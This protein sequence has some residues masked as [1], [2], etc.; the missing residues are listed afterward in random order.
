MK[1]Y[2]TRVP[3]FRL[4]LAAVLCFLACITASAQARHTVAEPEDGAR[5]SLLTPRLELVVGGGEALVVGSVHSFTRPGAL[6]SANIRS[7]FYIRLTDISGNPLDI[8]PYFDAGDRKKNKVWVVLPDN[9]PLVDA[10]NAGQTS[11]VFF[12]SVSPNVAWRGA[13]ASVQYDNP[14]NPAGFDPSY[15][16]GPKAGQLLH[17]ELVTVPAGQGLPGIQGDIPATQEYH[18]VRFY[19]RAPRNVALLGLTGTDRLR[20]QARISVG[21]G[22]PHGGDIDIESA[23]AEVSVVPD[24]VQNVEIF[25]SCGRPAGTVVPMEGWSPISTSDALAAGYSTGTPRNA[26][27]G[28]EFYKGYFFRSS[29]AVPPSTGIA[30]PTPVEPVNKGIGGFLA[31]DESLDR[32]CTSPI[33]LDTVMVSEHDQQIRVVARLLD[34]FNNPVGG[35]LVKFLVESE[36]LPITPPKTRKQ[37]NAQR[38]G[39]GEFGETFVSDDTVKRTTIGDTATAGWVTAFYTSGRVAHQIVRIALTPDTLAFDLSPNGHNLGEGTAVGES[40]RGF[41]PRVIV[42]VYV[43]SGPTVRVQI[44]PYTAAATSPVP[45]PMDLIAMQALEDISIYPD[46]RAAGY[47]PAFHAF[48]ANPFF[49][50]QRG[51]HLGRMANAN[52]RPY[53][54]D[55]LNLADDDRRSVNAV[56]AGRTVTLLARE[57]DRFGNLVEVQLKPPY[58]RNNVG[59]GIDTARII[60]RMWAESGA[61]PAPYGTGATIVP[62]LDWTRDEYGPMRKARYHHTQISTLVAG[63]FINQTSFFTALEY[64]TPKTTDARVC[65]SLGKRLA[66]S[67]PSRRDGHHPR[68]L[69]DRVRD[70]GAD[71]FRHPAGGTGIR[72]EP[73]GP[74]P[75]HGNP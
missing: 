4:T 44:Y 11:K 67:Q 75:R 71:A 68:H 1:Q 24:A 36:T 72:G 18:A 66:R 22:I 32:E 21:S 41:A 37:N 49:I 34:R 15:P 28:T 60:F 31:S 8:A 63:V 23:Y 74:F 51:T 17:A 50:D 42:P 46:T 19:L 5:A 62:A 12:G 47:G 13:G 10:F 20:I 35:R 26:A 58:D 73:R 14:T 33:P 39:F 56:T 45:L 7:Q 27:E 40:R 9:A 2:G 43:T 38:G 55:T 16:D 65:G 52:I 3:I 57:Y 70:Q 53:I 61:L 30:F 64:P 25:K 29:G 54:P 69:Q 6:K 48:S 59:N